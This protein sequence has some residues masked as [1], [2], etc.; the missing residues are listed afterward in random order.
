MTVGISLQSAWLLLPQFQRAAHYFLPGII[1][2]VSLVWLVRAVQSLVG[3]RRVPDLT[4]IPEP[5]LFPA[6]TG[7]PLLSV[8]VPAC[9]EE[10]AI[11]ATIRSLLNQRGIPLEVIA[12]NDRSSDSTGAILNRLQ[13]EFAVPAATLQTLRTTTLRVI[14]IDHLP[15]GWLGKPHALAQ[16]T[17]LATAPYLL[18]T[19]ADILF[20]ED[21]LLRA[22]HFLISQ[23]L[24]HL[25]L[26]STPISKTAGE[27]MMI[28]TLRT[29]GIW[30]LRLW[31][32]ADPRARDSI[33][34]GSFGLVPRATY[35]A[36]GGWKTFRMEVLED[37]RFGWEIKRRHGL[38]QQIAFGRDLLRLHWAA[39]A[40]GLAHNLTK[41]GFALFQYRLIAAIGGLLA[42]VVLLFLPLA[43][44]FG[45]PDLRWAFAPYL[46][47][48]VLLY[49]QDTGSTGT[50][51]AYIFLFPVGA[52]ILVYALAR[53][54]AFTL[55]RGGVVWRNT[56]YPLAQLRKAAGPLR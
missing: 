38:R 14:H 39:G 44:L 42:L 4:R 49:R 51:L 11:E 56:L 17:T 1:W 46:L 7:N 54:V 16:G 41:N 20:R 40:L 35:E 10:A 32:V 3:M 13:E 30:A 6:D 53:S 29:V 12:V 9:N 8:I 43:A 50:S 23:Q 47:A 48:L 19:D 22:V 21:A 31:K 33:G 37:L 15:D 25:V 34:V 5:P 18:F 24:D 27:R 45:P 52:A 55:L 36:V 28:S 26:A 2:L